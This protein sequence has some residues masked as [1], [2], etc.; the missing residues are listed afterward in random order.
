VVGIDQFA[1]GRCEGFGRG[2]GHGGF[3]Y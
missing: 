2:A 1:D 3:P